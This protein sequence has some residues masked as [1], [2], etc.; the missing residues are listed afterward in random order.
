MLILSGD[1]R[2]QSR[3]LSK[4]A[5]KFGR[6]FWPSRIFGEGIVKIVPIL[7]PLPRGTS[8]GVYSIEAWTQPASLKKEGGTKIM[9]IFVRI[10]GGRKIK[11]GRKTKLSLLKHTFALF[12]SYFLKNVL[13]R[14]ARSITFYFHP[15][16]RGRGTYTAGTVKSVSLLKVGRK[17]V[18]FPSHF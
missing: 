7:S 12:S 2:D 17:S 14:S 4:I 11:G 13:A 15:P 3:K 1:I 16:I 18:D 9:H 5:K 10:G 8:R 6:F